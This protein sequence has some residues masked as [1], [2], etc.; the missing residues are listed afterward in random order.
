MTFDEFDAL[1]SPWTGADDPF[2][3][4]GLE[5]AETSHFT[6]DF[7]VVDGF[8]NGALQVDEPAGYLRKPAGNVH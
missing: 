6:I 3:L 8:E 1:N 4:A 5:A 2:L 7:A